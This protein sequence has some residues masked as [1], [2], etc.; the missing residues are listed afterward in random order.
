[1][2]KALPDRPLLTA[3]ILSIGSELT[4][5]ETRDT[6]AGELARALTLEGVTVGRVTAVPDRLDVVTDM[7]QAALERSDLVVSTG[8]LGPTPDDLTRESIAAACGETPTVDPE[9]E[10]WLRERWARRGLSFPEINLKQAWVIPSCEPLANPN[11]S[12]PGWFVTRSDGRVVAALPG[13]PREMRPMWENEVLPRLRSRGLGRDLA[14]RTFRLTGIGESQ[15]AELLGEEMLRRPDPEVATYARLEAVD[16]RV[17]ASGSTGVGPGRTGDGSPA[18]ARVDEASAIVLERL[19]GYVWAEG[20]TTWS[21][22]I[23][24]RLGRLGWRLAVEEIGTGGQFAALL[25]D[26]E[27]LTLVEVRPLVV[28]SGANGDSGVDLIERARLVRSSAGVAVGLAVRARPRGTELA[29]SVAIVTPNGEQRQTRTTYTGG[30][31]GRT[32]SALLAAAALTA[33]LREEET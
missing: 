25:G 1:M 28:S 9:L 15:V 13:P 30:S 12:A 18:Q 20:D 16:V 19:G 23:G 5:G 29:V 22:A 7:F 3:E 6:N 4:V 26:V 33:A 31:L 14:V 17:S 8:G 27:W 2:S 21:A 24:E 32:Q 10:T 11:G